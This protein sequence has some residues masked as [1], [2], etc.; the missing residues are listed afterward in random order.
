[1]IKNSLEKGL[2]LY[3]LEPFNCA[4]KLAQIQKKGEATFRS[5]IRNMVLTSDFS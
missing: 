2:P 3:L 1:M 5:V 4:F